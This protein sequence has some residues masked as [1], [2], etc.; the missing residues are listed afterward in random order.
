[1]LI[2]VSFF[3]QKFTL[4]ELESNRNSIATTSIAALIFNYTLILIINFN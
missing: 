2:A 4:Y 3:D 1:M